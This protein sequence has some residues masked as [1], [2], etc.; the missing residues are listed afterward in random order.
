MSK[1]GSPAIKPPVLSHP[2]LY[3][4]K[5]LLWS[6]YFVLTLVVIGFFLGYVLTMG[7]ALLSFFVSQFNVKLGAR[8]RHFTESFQCA[9]IRFLLVIQPWLEIKTNHQAWRGTFKYFDDIGTRKV[10]FVANHRSNLDTFI[11]LSYF[12][13]LSGLAKR[14]LFY[15]LAFLPFMLFMGFI[16]VQKGDL[17]GFRDGVKKL[18]SQILDSERPVLIFP[19]TT[20]CAKYFEGANKFSLSV[21]KLALE[22]EA[23]LVPICLKNTDRVLGRGDWLLHPH[24]ASELLILTP[25]DCSKNLAFKDSKT[26]ADCVHKI[27][28]TALTTHSEPSSPLEVL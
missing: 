2:F 10:I 23:L 20:R 11:M 5:R 22:S 25:I 4:V 28:S 12:P 26:L 1:F 13:G 21:F 14:S 27:L 6:L 9:S 18:K 16:P 24:Q 3:N 8:L 19:E 17:N 7:L 15:N